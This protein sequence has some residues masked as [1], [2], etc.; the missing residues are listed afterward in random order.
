M[1]LY[2]SPG[3]CSLACH[4]VLREAGLDF[5]MERVDL[6]GKQTESGADFLT[7]NPKG[8]VPALA[9]DDGQLLTEG[10]VISQYIADQ[11]PAS[12]LAP[13]Q[14]S[15]ER[16]QVQEWLNF[17]GSEIHKNFSPLFNPH[18][19][20]EYKQ[21]C[22]QNLNRRLEF[23]AD[24]LKGR[25]YLLG[26]RFTVA[27]AYLFVVLTWGPKFGLHSDRWPSVDAFMHRMR[28]RPAVRAALEAEGLL[29]RS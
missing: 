12:E 14:G 16:Y 24:S 25:N 23:V 29:R 10:P 9:L 21:I 7:I 4:I 15:M 3:A 1:K 22:L 26:D 20:E 6:R 8:Y 5:D 18:A 13:A 19:P 28:E 11:A 2:Y 17:I 27:D